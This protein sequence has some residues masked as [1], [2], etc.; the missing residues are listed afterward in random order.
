MY[1]IVM[2]YLVG[3]NKKSLKNLKKL[4]IN[5]QYVLDDLLK[6]I[7]ESGPV[8]PSFSHYSKLSENEYHC[9]LNYHWVACWRCENGKYKVEVY[10]VGSRES[11]PY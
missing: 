2:R 4:P 6:A 8:Q 5:A 9:H 11:A 7:E 10:Y 3:L 1:I